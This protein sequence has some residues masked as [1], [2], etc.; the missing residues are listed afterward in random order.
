M[1]SS[2]GTGSDD[3][4]NNAANSRDGPSNGRISHVG[5]TPPP[6]RYP[7]VITS[8]IEALDEK[9]QTLQDAIGSVQ[10]ESRYYD[11]EQA[12]MSLCKYQGCQERTANSS[13][14]TIHQYCNRLAPVTR[15][16]PELLS[17]I[18][19]LSVRAAGPGDWIEAAHT[20]SLVCK[21]WRQIALDCPE[22]WSHLNDERNYSPM[23]LATMV[24][25]SCSV[26]LSF[27]GG[28]DVKAWPEDGRMAL[29][30]NNMHRFKSIDLYIPSDH[31]YVTESLFSA[32]SQPAPALRRLTI[33]SNY[34]GGAFPLEFLNGCAPNLRYVKLKFPLTVLIPWRSALFSDLVTLIVDGLWDQFG[35][36]HLSSL[37]MLLA[38]LA[39]MPGL[40]CLVLRCS[41]P[42][43]AQSP[44]TC[45]HVDLPNLRKF[46][47]KGSLNRCTDFLGKIAINA[48]TTPLLDLECDGT[49]VEDI[50]GF[51]AVLTHLWITP[52][53]TR[54]FKF[55]WGGHHFGFFSRPAQGLHVVCS[56]NGNIT[57]GF[58][59]QWAWH[60][61]TVFHFTT[62]A[63]SLRD[64]SGGETG[65]ALPPKDSGLVNHHGTGLDWSYILDSYRSHMD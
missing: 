49:M 18:F 25:R 62:I 51:Q 21:R 10:P 15:L 1:D 28:S 3:S 8:S 35:D 17:L 27:I 5:T 65:I 50:Y 64:G 2:L 44:M 11:E 61:D 40:E 29:V 41:I 22:L 58:Y 39:K 38:A 59:P 34:C 7:S 42:S 37:E 26:P 45:A 16:P 53:P 30:V 31:H 60:P 4:T 46:E 52:V 36:P 54:T 23:W 20:N 63:S 14:A 13:L 47:L 56:R 19:V 55:A 24:E 32:F 33:T 9:E 6:E 12:L 48:N 43:P 57:I